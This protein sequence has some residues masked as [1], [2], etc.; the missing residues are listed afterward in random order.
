M[1]F[2]VYPFKGP[3]GFSRINKK[4]RKKY[5]KENTR[6]F[7]WAKLKYL[8]SKRKTGIR[9]RGWK[10]MPWKGWYRRKLIS[11]YRKTKRGR[12]RKRIKR[13]RIASGPMS[14]EPVIKTLELRLG[15]FTQGTIFK[16]TG[17][18]D[19]VGIRNVT[20][21]VN[22]F[23]ENQSFLS[24]IYL[25]AV[26]LKAKNRMPVLGINDKRILSKVPVRADTVSNNN[27]LSY[28]VVDRHNGFSH[29]ITLHMNFRR[30]RW[31]KKDD[32]VALMLLPNAEEVNMGRERITQESETGPLV[33]LHSGKQIDMNM[34]FSPLDRAREISTV[35]AGTNDLSVILSGSYRMNIIQK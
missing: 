2:R 9:R 12:G 3:S 27:K 30:I 35:I 17:S 13:R 23:V 24:R 25:C 32:R 8:R 29:L 22:A 15:Y 10:R 16:Y 34:T 20:I 26:Y 31:M 28:L 21:S 14:V 7:G 4:I 18:E 33:F 6:L 11:R 5:D 1:D 19:R